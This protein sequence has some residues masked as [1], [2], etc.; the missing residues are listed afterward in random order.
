MS[1]FN[2]KNFIIAL[3]LAAIVVFLMLQ[4]NTNKEKISQLDPSTI[5][6]LE[7]MRKNLKGAKFDIIKTISEDRLQTNS[8]KLIAYYH[9]YDCSNCVHKVMDAITNLDSLHP[10]LP[11]YI[12]SNELESKEQLV[13]N[14][15]DAPFITDKEGQFQTQINYSY[16]PVIFYLDKDQVVK[17]LYHATTPTF[18]RSYTRFISV[19]D[20]VKNKR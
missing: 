12:I 10:N 2:K 16:S 4:F 6:K 3:I 8:P 20:S 5:E 18:Q 17:E 1:A 9:S 13:N 7:L 14:N 19:L 15:I 11:I